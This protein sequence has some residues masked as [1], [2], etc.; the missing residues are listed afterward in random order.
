M[1]D[2]SF[3]FMDLPKE[4][5]LI[6]YEHLPIVMTHYKLDAEWDGSFENGDNYV[7]PGGV[8]VPKDSTIVLH[9][10]IL[11]VALL[12]TSRKLVS[13]ASVILQPKLEALRASP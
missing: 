11:G 1:T 2:R 4:L 9:Q 7:S 12:R 13:E 6:M 10:S 5:R 3:R 8:K